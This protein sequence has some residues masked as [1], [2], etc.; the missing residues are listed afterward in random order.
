MR[1]SR[2]TCHEASDDRNDVIS[3][4]LIF[5]IRLQANRQLTH[6]HYTTLVCCNSAVELVYPS[7]P[8]T[9]ESKNREKEP[10]E[11]AVWTTHLSTP[12]S[13]SSS[14]SSLSSSWEM[15][16]SCPQASHEVA[17]QRLHASTF[18]SKKFPISE[19]A[20]LLKGAQASPV[21]PSGK[22]NV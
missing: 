15:D 1:C 18:L 17:A 16:L 19:G 14:S 20:L 6:Q 7:K 8:K 21:C 4:P 5:V 3:K 2:E 12:T 11:G 10:T 13:S 9:N 22:S